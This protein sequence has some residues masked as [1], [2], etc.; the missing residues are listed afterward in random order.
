MS[1][2][3]RIKPT[4]LTKRV[5]AAWDVFRRG[6]PITRLPERKARYGMMGWPSLGDE[7]PQWHLIDYTTYVE[8]GV[9]AN[10]VIYA[11]IRYK[12]QSIAAAPLRAYGGDADHPEP[13]DA[14]HPLAKLVARPNPYQDWRALQSQADAF[15][16]VSGNAYF[17]LRRK[18]GEGLPESI[19]CPR[20]D[21]VFVI[22][23]R[24]TEDGWVGLKGYW[25]TPEGMPWGKGIPI[26]PKNMMHVKLPNP[27]DPLNGL[28]EGLSPLGPG[29]YSTDVDNSITRF[30]K[31][32]F[33][34]GGVPPYWFTFDQPV[35]DATIAALKEEVQE[36]YGGHENWTKPGVLGSG[37]DVKR[38]G[39]TFQEMGFGEIDE[40]TESRILGPLGVPGALIGTR[41]GLM[42]AIRANMQ[43]LR[44][45]FWEDT[46]IPELELFGAEYRY[47]LQTDD[48]AFVKFDYSRVPALQ[49]DIPQLVEAAYRMWS[50]GTPASIAYE[51]VGMAVKDI[52][53]GDTGY[54][55]LGVIPV[56]SS[57]E[58]EH[59]EE[60]GAEAED[61]TRKGLVWVLPGDSKKDPAR[62]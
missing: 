53:G 31:L 4:G 12:W 28:G 42:R 61:D 29:A 45:L 59:T 23:D 26:L 16:N 35:D 38:V 30:L 37:G 50:M 51:T 14:D 60:G 7:Q 52:P 19:A 43:E 13:L 3:S 1:I 56:G 9:N 25:Y 6:Y 46:M 62:Q 39:L 22:P 10:A 15:L 21:R 20:P 8:E 54:V 47:Y 33:E 27:G 44:K 49:K 32:F 57:I 48:G 36:M 40:R 41:L 58:P 11:A 5:S 17:W 2:Y 34:R 24:K 18:R 55:P